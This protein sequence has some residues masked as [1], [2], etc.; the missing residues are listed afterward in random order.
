MLRKD[1]RCGS[2]YYL[3]HYLCHSASPE[4]PAWRCRRDGPPVFWYCQSS[5]VSGALV[6]GRRPAAAGRAG[7]GGGG[8]ARLATTPESCRPSQSCRSP[9]CV[10]ISSPPLNVA[11]SSA[12]MCTVPGT[13]FSA[14]TR[15]AAQRIRRVGDRTAFCD[16]PALNG[17]P[18][19]TSEHALRLQRNCQTQDTMLRSR[20]MIDGSGGGRVALAVCQWLRR[21]G[22]GA[23]VGGSDGGRSALADS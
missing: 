9:Y 23:V 18:A 14:A 4:R 19:F 3:C 7:D 22:L 10:L 16:R 20:A 13:E 15:S 8:E 12:Y 6:S 1:I 11:V 2:M 17:R 21:S 5:G